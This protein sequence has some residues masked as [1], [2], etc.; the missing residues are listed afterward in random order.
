MFWY[1]FGLV[2]YLQTREQQGEYQIPSHLTIVKGDENDQATG[3]DVPIV[4]KK[5]R[6]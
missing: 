5:G 1:A 4:Q 2:D 6:V 3:E